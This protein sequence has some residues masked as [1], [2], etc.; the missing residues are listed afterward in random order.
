MKM[1]MKM[2]NGVAAVLLAGWAVAAGAQP[3]LQPLP[4]L[5]VAGYMGTWYQVLWIPNR[6]QKQCVSDTAATYRDLGDG[7]VEVSNRC[8]LANGQTDSVIGVAR[9]PAGVSRIEAGKL[10]PARLE[11][12]FLPAW[13]RWTGI[14]WGAYWVVD[15]ASDG[16]Y[17]IV[18]EAS[19]EYLWVLSR[20]PA[21]TTEDEAAIRAR[22]G[23]LGF[24]LA[25]VQNHPHQAAA[26]PANT[27]SSSAP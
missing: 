3:A 7:R 16:R 6:F 1:K 19:R 11:V 22:L 17:A 23:Q 9:P 21:L 20:K 5:D 24:D 26:Q 18:S 2:K 25:Q 27:R 14:G 4:S 12:S 10:M 13:L 15:L 8:R